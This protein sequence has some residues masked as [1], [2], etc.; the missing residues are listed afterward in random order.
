M[1]IRETIDNAVREA[2]DQEM[3]EIDTTVQEKMDSVD[4]WMD[5]TNDRLDKIE[6]MVK[7]GPSPLVNRH[8]ASVGLAFAAGAIGYAGHDGWGWCLLM[9]W[10][11][12]S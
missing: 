6:T 9:I 3:E 12:E 4:E 2:V 1:T 5:E 8:W 11:I 7:E 10:I